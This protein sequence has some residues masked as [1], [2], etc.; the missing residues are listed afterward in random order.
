[1]ARPA[2]DEHKTIYLF[3]PVLDKGTK[4][5]V[6]AFRFRGQ[7][8]LR[9]QK[10]PVTKPEFLAWVRAC[11]PRPYPIA[12]GH[13][14]MVEVDV[15]GFDSGLYLRRTPDGVSFAPEIG[16]DVEAESTTEAVATEA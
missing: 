15:L 5:Y 11:M 16:S 8:C 10:S 1:M 13:E 9:T 3:S 7:G 6:M 4:A 12:A 2:A 14:K